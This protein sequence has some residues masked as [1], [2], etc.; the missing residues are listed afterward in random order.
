M[1]KDLKRAL[2]FYRDILGLRVVKI[3]PDGNLIEFSVVN[4]D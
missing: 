3:I 2:R 4:N 1:V